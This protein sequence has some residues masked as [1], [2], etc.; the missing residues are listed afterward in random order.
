MQFKVFARNPEVVEPSALI[1][2]FHRWIQQDRITDDVLIDVADYTH[3]WHGPAVLLVCH[4]VNYA[5]DLGEGRPGLLTAWKR[6]YEGTAADRLRTIMGRAFRACALLEDDPDANGLTFRTNEFMVRIPDRL[7]APN[8]PE[9]FDALRTLLASVL[10]TLG[11]GHLDVEPV[12]RPGE[13][14][15][16]LVRV[17][18]LGTV[19][20]LAETMGFGVAAAA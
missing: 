15:T 16:A 10:A 3:V 20:E 1:P 13:P 7:R 12:A 5:Y 2:V 11:A 8:T 6:P 18:G 4:G 17:A 14:L 9:T 19:G